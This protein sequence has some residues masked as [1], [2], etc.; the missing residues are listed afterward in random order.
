M[1]THCQEIVDVVVNVQLHLCLHPFAINWIVASCK[2]TC[3]I[4]INAV[5]NVNQPIEYNIALSLK[6]TRPEWFCKYW[7][8]V[9]V[10]R[11]RRGATKIKKPSVEFP[12]CS[13]I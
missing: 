6:Y 2:K 9:L 8:S 7:L 4:G 1:I 12:Y 10:L 5:V 13:R 11:Q 3:T